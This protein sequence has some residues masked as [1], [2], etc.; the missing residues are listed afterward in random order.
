MDHRSE[1][2]LLRGGDREGSA[3]CR[4]STENSDTITNHGII[5]T[6]ANLRLLTRDDSGICRDGEPCG[7]KQVAKR[8]HVGVLKVVSGRCARIT[9]EAKV[10]F[11]RPAQQSKN[12][13]AG[14]VILVEVR[15]G[16]I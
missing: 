2:I 10:K 3:D 1:G 5:D 11:Q 8:R 9:I 14:A 7:C 6:L 16:A 15:A 12:G 4:S 13:R